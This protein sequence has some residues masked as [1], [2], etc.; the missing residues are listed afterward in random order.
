MKLQN[1]CHRGAENSPF[2]KLEAGVKVNFGE[3]LIG[4]NNKIQPWT[5][6]FIVYT[7]HTVA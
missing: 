3:I 7:T 1:F 4:W 5:F 6:C 2:L